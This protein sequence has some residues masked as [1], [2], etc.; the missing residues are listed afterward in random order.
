MAEL[1]RSQRSEVRPLILNTES[2]DFFFRAITSPKLIR[3][4][5]KCSMQNPWQKQCS[6]LM[7]VKQ[8]LIQDE[9]D[10]AQKFYFTSSQKLVCALQHVATLKR[11][12]LHLWSFSAP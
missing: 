5:L 7:L 1:K 6:L 8:T 9:F 11:H 4:H 2:V 10:A 12:H 3:R